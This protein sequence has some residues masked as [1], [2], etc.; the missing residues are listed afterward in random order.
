M[1]ETGWADS[2][3]A[4]LVD[5]WRVYQDK[6]IEALQPLTPEG[7]ALRPAP[8]LRS[9]GETALHIISVRAN[10]F[11]QALGIGDQ[12][13]AAFGSWQAPGA[14]DRTAAELVAALRA[15]WAVMT[16]AMAAMTPG[17]LAARVEGTRR[18]QP[19][20]LVRGWVIWHLIEHDLHH[21]G[22]ISYTLGM[23]GA[24]GLDI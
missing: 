6:L 9:V 2:T 23:Q 15:T 13:F 18:G 8:G 19:F 21:G 11:V 12:D 3:L 24:P 1:T 16:T 7:L 10:W 20:S 4:I 14:P 17:D 22:E 5:G